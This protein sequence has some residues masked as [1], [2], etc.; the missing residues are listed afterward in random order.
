MTGPPAT[1]TVPVAF[2][3]CGL[4]MVLEIEDSLA[5]SVRELG[6]RRESRGGDEEEGSGAA[7]AWKAARV[8]S[9]FPA[10]TVMV[11]RLALGASDSWRALRGRAASWEG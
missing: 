1:S 10:H 6:F 4:H 2:D 11:A 8:H 5:R 7:A 3:L 9:A